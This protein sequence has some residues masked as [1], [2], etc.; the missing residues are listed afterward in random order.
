[1]KSNV[2]IDPNG[3]DPRIERII[4][5]FAAFLKL[6]S[7]SGLLLMFA[8]LAA[9]TWANSPWAGSY[10]TTWNSTFSISYGSA[11]SLSKPLVLWINDGLMAVFFLL[12]G[13][14]IKREIT[15]GELN[16]RSSA[17]LP[18]AAALGGMVLPA[19]IYC[20]LNLGHPSIRGWGVPMATDI[21]FS[22]GILALVGSRVPLALKVFLTALAIVDDLGAVAV[23]AAFYTDQIHWPMLGAALGSWVALMFLGK[24]G[25]RSSVLFALVGC[26]VWVCMLKSGVHA[27]IAGVLVAFAIPATRRPDEQYSLAE[28]WEHGLHPWVAFL[29]VPVFALANAGVTLDG[30][31]VASAV[32][33]IS[34]GIVAGLF[35]G[36]LM[37]VTGFS[38]LAVRLGWASLPDG[39]RW[40][41]IVGVSLLAGVGFTMSLFI[42]DLAFD[43]PADVAA[44]R[45]GILIASAVAGCA[46]FGVLR[47]SSARRLSLP[48]VGNLAK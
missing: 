37:G 46:G 17:A 47:F 16:S 4:S 32:Q 23:I 45:I 10:A 9:I 22:L 24:L 5:P 43:A 12:V 3:L 13:L 35:L 27:T 15:T 2:P 19:V 7:A 30:N 14:E 28:R 25:V 29:I 18:A 6:E 42:A 34:I 41:D 44:A 36:K 1:V 39:I 11:F 31:A 33:P 26:V 48:T 21:A 8:A 38:W 20:L 40:L